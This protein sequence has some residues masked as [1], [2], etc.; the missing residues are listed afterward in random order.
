MQFCTVLLFEQKK[1]TGT[2]VLIG[3]WEHWPMCWYRPLTIYSIRHARPFVNTVLLLWPGVRPPG[4]PTAGTA[5]ARAAAAGRSA[6]QDDTLKLESA[7]AIIKQR[8]ADG[9][10]SLKLSRQQFL[11]HVDCVTESGAAMWSRWRKKMVNIWEFQYAGRV[12]ITDIDGKIFE[13]DVVAV[14]DAGE[15]VDEKDSIDIDTGN[16]I[17]GFNPE[18]IAS[19]E[20]VE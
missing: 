16:E 4:G 8:V 10:Y 1:R 19:I 3:V 14:F 18:E 2:S 7:R 5:S 11:K 6:A 12:R 15:T 9:E 20:A 13:G 17:V